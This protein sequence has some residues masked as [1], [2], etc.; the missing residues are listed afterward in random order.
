MK[1]LNFQKIK[2]KNDS[3]LKYYL[4]HNMQQ[5]IQKLQILNYI[6]K[7]KSRFVYSRLVVSSDQQNL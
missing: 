6:V 2:F 3:V 5:P 7:K 4:A 1:S